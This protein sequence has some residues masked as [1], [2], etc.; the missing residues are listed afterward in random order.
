MVANLPYNVASVILIEALYHLHPPEF[1]SVMV[2]K[3]VARRIVGQ[4]NSKDYS[5]MSVLVQAAADAKITAVVPPGAFI[6]PPKVHSA[7]VRID[8]RNDQRFDYEFKQYFRQFATRFFRHRRKTLRS[9]FI[10]TFPKE[11]TDSIHRLFEAIPLES[12][13]RPE[14]VNVKTIRTLSRLFFDAK[15]QFYTARG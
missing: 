12:S 1:M 4:T 8:Y 13:L 6:P 3:E 14:A 9:G 5:V 15:I 11:R 2:Q 7:I 10:N